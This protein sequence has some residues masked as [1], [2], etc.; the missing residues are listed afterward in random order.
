MKP[1]LFK[2]LFYGSGIIGIAIMLFTLLFI[3]PIC[4][5]GAYMQ[6][7]KISCAILG[8][9][10]VFMATVLIYAARTDRKR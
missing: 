2:K 6:P 3:L 4:I 5:H 8:I 9:I 1:S 7:I 10:V